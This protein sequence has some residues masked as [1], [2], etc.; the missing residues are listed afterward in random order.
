MTSKISRLNLRVDNDLMLLLEEIR[1][2]KG[3]RSISEVV[4]DALSRYLD[5]EADS[6]NSE[7]V[8]IRIPMAMLD[9]LESLIM[10]GDAT[11]LTQTV[12]F[13][14]NEW[15]RTKKEY[16]LEGRDAL[17]RKVEEIVGEREAKRRMRSEAEKMR[18]R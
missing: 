8:K 11:D 7:L 18:E 14:L 13:A 6:W 4:R 17:K 16:H 2:R 1:E 12:N 9:D 15:V 5:E 10:A 3:M